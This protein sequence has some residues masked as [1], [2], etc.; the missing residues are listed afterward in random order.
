MPWKKLTMHNC[1][2][3]LGVIC[4][5]NM[6]RR[7]ESLDQHTFVISFSMSFPF[8][9]QLHSLSLPL[10]HP[11]L[12]HSATGG[13]NL[14]EQPLPNLSFTC[15][16][17]YSPLQPRFCT[18]VWTH[19]LCQRCRG[20]RV[21]ITAPKRHSC[22]Q[23]VEHSNASLKKYCEGPVQ[24]NREHWS[25]WLIRLNKYKSSSLSSYHCICLYLK[26]KNNTEVAA[27][28]LEPL[29]FWK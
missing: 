9:C 15:F 28:V 17:Y 2:M 24:Q 14:E 29:W 23:D 19:T 18:I 4:V 11:F 6:I 16:V 27:H 21:S 8:C 1:S 26:S 25:I 12:H 3:R 22:S 5:F 7:G 20:T 10:I 13:Q